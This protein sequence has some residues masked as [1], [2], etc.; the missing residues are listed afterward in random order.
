MANKTKNIAYV[1]SGAFIA[2]LD[3]SDSYHLLFVRL[4]S[5]PPALITTTLVIAE[6]HGWFLKRYDISRAIEFLNFIDTLN[7]LKI[8]EV[9]AMEIKKASDSIRKYSDQ[10][11]TIADALGLVIMNQLKIKICWSVDR[12]LSLN[13]VPIVIN[14]I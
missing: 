8:L 10:E 2:F 6:C 5:D 3:R 11:L 13:G 4:F 9:G 1:D 12:D 14:H 7:V